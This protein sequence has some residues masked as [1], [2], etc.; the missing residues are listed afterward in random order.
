MSTSIQVLSMHGENNPST[1]RYDPKV[2]PHP[3]GGKKFYLVEFFEETVKIDVFL[4][5]VGPSHTL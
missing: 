3:E 2:F 4:S 5:F 1:V